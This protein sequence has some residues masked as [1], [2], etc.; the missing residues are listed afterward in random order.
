[1]NNTEIV[2]RL[3][4]DLERARWKQAQLEKE[5]VY[6]LNNIERRTNASRT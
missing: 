6:L 5:I 4:R 3:T 1:M 2:A